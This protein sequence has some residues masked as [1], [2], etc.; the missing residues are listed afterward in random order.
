MAKSQHNER[1]DEGQ[2]R[3]SEEE[4]EEDED[5]DSGSED[6]TPVKK[7]TKTNFGTLGKRFSL[8]QLS[9]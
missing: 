4:E 7:T 3:G 2:G 1:A 8:S 5:E 6:E 9:R